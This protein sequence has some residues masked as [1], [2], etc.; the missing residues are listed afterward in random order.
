[1]EICNRLYSPSKEEIAKAEKIIS[2]F[3]A[4]EKLGLAAIQVDGKFID[5]PV[6][7][8]A[9]TTLKIA[10]GIFSPGNDP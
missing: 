10:A 8:Q 1:V 7:A 3:E 2:A 9:R 6:V 5:Y 4:A